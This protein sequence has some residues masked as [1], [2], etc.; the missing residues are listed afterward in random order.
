VRGLWKRQEKSLASQT[1][2]LRATVQSALLSAASPA[3]KSALLFA[4]A[5]GRCLLLR[6]LAPAV[7]SHTREVHLSELSLFSAM[8]RSTLGGSDD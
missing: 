7:L 3:L 4:V 2:H 5:D 6:P 8:R 1:A